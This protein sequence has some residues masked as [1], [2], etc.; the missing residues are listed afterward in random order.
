MINEMT[1]LLTIRRQLID[2]HI[3]IDFDITLHITIFIYHSSLQM[4]K[5]L[6]ILIYISYH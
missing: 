4:D 3:Q 1:K 2:I 6:M 5:W